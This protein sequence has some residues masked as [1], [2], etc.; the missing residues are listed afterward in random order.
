MYKYREATENDFNEICSLIKSREEMFLVYPKGNYPLTVAQ[1]TELSKERMELTV[2]VDEFGIVGFANIYDY[3]ENE[4]VFIGNVIIE[5][6]YRGKG[7]GKEIVSYMLE[8]AFVKYGLC[9]VRI[10]VFSENIPALLLYSNF[11]FTPYALEE[12]KNH[13]GRRVALIHMKMENNRLKG[14][15]LASRK[16]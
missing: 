7:L 16:K 4:Y 13:E 15:L 12:R 11:G 9:E 14:I 5:K 3:N 8:K 1:I 2:A 10:S 6:Q